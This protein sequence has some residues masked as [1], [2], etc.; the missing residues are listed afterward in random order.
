MAN[1]MNPIMN[2]KVIYCHN[3]REKGPVI[4]LKVDSHEEQ[5]TGVD[6][7]KLLVN[8]K[9]TA[10]TLEYVIDQGNWQDLLREDLPSW[11]Y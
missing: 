5:T 11:L 4:A 1:P 7:V 6:G 8:K 10:L 3:D 9:T 2:S